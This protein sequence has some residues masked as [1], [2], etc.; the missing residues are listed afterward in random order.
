MSLRGKVD[1]V[2][3]T[4]RGLVREHYEDHIGSNLDV[5]LAI[6]AD[7][8]GGL[9]AGE[10]AS[11][12]A[13][14]LISFELA[15]VVP[16]LEV[17]GGD[18]ASGHT[19]ESLA[20]DQ[21]VKKANETIYQVAQ[22]QPQCAGMGTTLVLIL[23]YDN[24]ITIAH[25]GDSRLYRL[26]K[27]TFEQVTVD[28]SLIQELVDRGFYTREEARHSAN[29][30]IVTRAIGIAPSVE[31]EVQEQGARLGDLFLMCS[32]GLNDMVVDDDIQRIIE[33]YEDDLEAAAQALVD[34]ANANG[35]RDNIS[36]I[37]AKVRKPFPHRTGLM[38][39]VLRWFD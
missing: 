12:M 18:G 33:L 26:R 3:L 28:H 38:D 7:G 29:K 10:V 35:G 22:S 15:Q 17:V 13:V 31:V 4:D 5:G 25:V 23:L 9:N 37:L 2:A 36:V 14:E 39:R 6:L 24:H 20:V 21:A 32:D 8:M 11:A 19:L 16:N 34:T 30:N 27:G 1:I